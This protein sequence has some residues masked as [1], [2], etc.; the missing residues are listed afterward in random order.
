MEVLIVAATEL[1]VVSENV[2]NFPVLITGVGMVN[3][4]I[5]LTKELIK[6]DYDLVINMGIAGSFSDDVKIGDVVEVVED[7]F[8]EIGFE[9]GDKFSEFTDFKIKTTYS[10][11][12]KT[13]LRKA[14]GVTINTVHG[15][16][17]SITEIVNRI[18]SDI[19]TMEGASVFK[20]CEELDVSYMQIR[21]ISNNVEIRNKDNWDIDLAIRN[22]NSEVEKIIDTL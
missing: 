2:R 19:E 13:N 4:A 12:S 14:K 22:L 16:E 5:N 8:S 21:A 3:T 7:T 18:N 15:K 6:S 9:D 1:E 10:V 20:V 17:D 11:K